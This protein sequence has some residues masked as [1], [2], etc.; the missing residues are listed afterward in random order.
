MIKALFTHLNYMKVKRTLFLFGFVIFQLVIVSSVQANQA[1]VVDVKISALGNQQYRIDTTLSHSDTGW[2]H[3]ANAWFVYDKS[4]RLLG[5]RVLHHPHVDEQ[6]FT[7]SLTL[8]IPSTIKEIVIKAQDS[9]HGLNEQGKTVQ[10]P[11]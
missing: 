8:K 7:R 3:Y 10:V 2:K 6:P 1:Q 9:I 11:N 5:E 4:G